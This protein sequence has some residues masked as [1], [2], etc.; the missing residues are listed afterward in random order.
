[1]K[2]LQKKHIDELLSKLYARTYLVQMMHEDNGLSVILQM[3]SYVANSKV[4]VHWLQ[5]ESYQKALM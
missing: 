1:M 3:D 2:D 5:E 4:V